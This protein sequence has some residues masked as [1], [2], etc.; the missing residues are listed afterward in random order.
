V[1]SP[2]QGSAGKEREKVVGEPAAVRK[3][4]AI[5]L[6]RETGISK[7]AGTAA[8][9]PT[10]PHTAWGNKDTDDSDSQRTKG[11]RH[12]PRARTKTEPEEMEREALSRETRRE[13]EKLS[14]ARVALNVHQTLLFLLKSSS[15]HA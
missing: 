4:L 12:N 14:G 11:Q 6:Q 8:T 9:P 3:S 5:D 10:R 2:W 7:E 1:G 15:R 13:D